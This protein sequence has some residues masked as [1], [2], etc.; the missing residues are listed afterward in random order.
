MNRTM[1]RI[2]E[3]EGKRLQKLEWNDFKDVTREAFEK[4]M[5]FD[6]K[7]SK[8]FPDLVFQNNKYIVQ[9]FHNHVRNGK[10]YTKAMIRRSDA[11][12]ICDWSD[13]FRIK[14]EIFGD[15]VEAVQ[16]LPK[17]SELVDRANLYWFFIE[18][19][20]GEK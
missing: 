17:K 14:N 10:N 20:E 19:N 3:R 5:M 12:P 1:R 7:T 15:E 9:V 2:S 16:F 4:H 11:A 6:G 8:Y 18:R 13:L